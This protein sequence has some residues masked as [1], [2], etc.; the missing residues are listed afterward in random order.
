MYV[1][2]WLCRI[3]DARSHTPLPIITP[4]YPIYNDHHC[5]CSFHLCMMRVHFRYRQK[6]NKALVGLLKDV[7]LIMIYFF[8]AYIE[9][10]QKIWLES[11]TF[12]RKRYPRIFVRDASTHNVIT[13]VHKDEILSMSFALAFWYN[14]EMTENRVPHCIFRNSII[15]CCLSV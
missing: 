7:S 13:G 15:T 2:F 9:I 11:P 10:E 4:D 6:K 5:L 12:F 1:R 8:W 3:E 14:V